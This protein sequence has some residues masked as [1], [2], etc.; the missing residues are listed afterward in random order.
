M[1]KKHSQVINVS[2][3]KATEFGKGQFGFKSKRL[4]ANSGAQAIGCNWFELASGK[5][6][7]PYHYHTGIEENL[8]VLK[9]VGLLRIGQE[10]LT[11]KEGDYISFP[12][13]PAFAHSLKNNGKDPLQY[14]VMSN[15]SHVDVVGYPDSKKLAVLATPDLNEWPPQSAWIRLIINE[16][17]SVDYFEGEN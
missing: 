7:F 8:F 1:I 11:V 3:V 13:G 10:T 2:D 15:K 17:Q 5:T 16:Q 4:A 6:A 12:A 9:G 14:L